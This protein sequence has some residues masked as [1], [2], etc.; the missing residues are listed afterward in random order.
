MLNDLTFLDIKCKPSQ[1]FLKDRREFFSHEDRKYRNAK[2]IPSIFTSTFDSIK[3]VLLFEPGERWNYGVNF[4]WVGKVV[5]AV[6]GKR[7]GEVM[8]E[9]I[10]APLGMTDIGFTLTPSMTERRATIH[11]RAQDGKITPRPD[12]LLPRPPERVLHNRH[13][14]I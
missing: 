13:H 1:I 2:E 10:F 11:N 12:L 7:L 8:A 5:E 9:R 14:E 4:D 3:S 6:R